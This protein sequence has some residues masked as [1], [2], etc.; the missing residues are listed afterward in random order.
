MDL[1]YKVIN[2]SKYKTV[3][4]VL[5][6]YFHMSNRLITKTKKENKIFLNGSNTYIDKELNLN[7]EIS[8]NLDFKETSDNIVP[9]KM[10][11]NILFE[12]ESIIAI[13][14]TCGIPVHPSILHYSDSLSNGVKFYFEE[15]CINKKIR[16]VNRLDKDTSGIVIFAKN[17]YIQE[18]L[19]NQMKS[20]KFKKYYLALLEG[21][22]EKSIGTINAPISRKEGSIIEREINSNGDIAITHYKLIKKYRNENQDLSLVQFKLETGRTHQLRVHSKYINHPILGDYL[23]GKKSNLISR[24]ALHAYKVCFIHPITHSNIILESPLPDDINKIIKT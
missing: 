24:Q 7:D 13:D 9:T 10:N 12:D 3:K 2:N 21:F 18:S 4:S 11:L 23:Y 20:G 8:V 5:K 14:K 22:L 16:P 15:K 6:S 17:E 19:I 1:K